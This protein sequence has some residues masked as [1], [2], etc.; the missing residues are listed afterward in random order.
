M[1]SNA[2]FREQ[3]MNNGVVARKTQAQRHRE[4]MA[5]RRID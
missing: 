4:T 1:K 3:T 5:K 2:K